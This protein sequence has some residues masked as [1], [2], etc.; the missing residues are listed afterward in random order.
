MNWSR[1]KRPSKI[2]KIKKNPSKKRKSK[3]K[4]K[5]SGGKVNCNLANTSH[6]K[7]RIQQGSSK[8]PNI[9]NRP[10]TNITQ[11]NGKRKMQQERR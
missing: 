3:S 5:L 8:C 10:K 9:G 7:K 6:L 11:S 2:Q 4:R 1:K